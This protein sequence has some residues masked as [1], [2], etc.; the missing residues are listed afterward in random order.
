M[1][2]LALIFLSVAVLFEAKGETKEL[3][4]ETKKQY[5]TYGV[6]GTC[7]GGSQNL[8]LA[9]FNNDGIYEI[10]TGGFAY[11]SADAPRYAPITIWDWNG[12][13]LT[14]QASETWGGS[15]TSIYASDANNDGKIELLTAGSVSGSAG[16]TPEF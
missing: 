13:N 3:I 14:L 6:G 4:L 10:I 12:T 9:D 16:S 15:T 2:V 1:F 11:S 5:D 8:A 7:V